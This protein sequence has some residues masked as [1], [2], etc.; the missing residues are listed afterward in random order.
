MSRPDPFR[1]TL[2]KPALDWGGPFPCPNIT[3]FQIRHLHGVFALRPIL[4]RTSTDT[5]ALKR[6]T[7]GRGEL[8]INGSHSG[9]ALKILLSMGGSLDRPF[10]TFLSPDHEGWVAVAHVAR[11]VPAKLTPHMKLWFSPA[12]Q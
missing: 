5:V 4:N 12:S 2:N 6:L 7:R 9:E 1:L 11:I 10:F 8:H 3:G